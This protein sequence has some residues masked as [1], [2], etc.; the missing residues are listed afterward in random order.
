MTTFKAGDG[1]SLA[2]TLK[3][4]NGD[5]FTATIVIPPLPLAALFVDDFLTTGAPSDT[6]TYSA[7]TDRYTKARAS[8][9][10]VGASDDITATL[11]YF[12]IGGGSTPNAASV[13]LSNGS[14]V[15]IRYNPLLKNAANAYARVA[16]APRVPIPT[17]YSPTGIAYKAMKRLYQT[18]G[19]AVVMDSELGDGTLGFKVQNYPLVVLESGLVWIYPDHL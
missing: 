6:L 19:R 11:S 16:T 14:G 5:D 8:C 3:D 7:A 4:L 1:L 18:G 13:I 15:R 2:A 9:T 12:P 10:A 17:L